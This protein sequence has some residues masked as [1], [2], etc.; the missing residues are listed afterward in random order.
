[1]T[2]AST[3]RQWNSGSAGQVHGYAQSSLGFARLSSVRAARTPPIE[4][5]LQRRISATLSR[6]C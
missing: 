2:S 6:R 1:M 3:A 4:S 5:G